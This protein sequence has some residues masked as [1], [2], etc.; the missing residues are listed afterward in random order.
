MLSIALAACAG[1]ETAATDAPSESPMSI[2]PSPS[3]TATPQPSATPTQSAAPSPSTSSGGGLAHDSMV[4]TVVDQVALRDGARTAGGLIGY[5]PIGSRS[6]V[7]DGPVSADGYEWM[8]LVGP[9]IPP[10]SGCATFPTRELT[11]PV[12]FGWA[13]IADPVSGDPWFADD[14]SECPEVD[15]GDTRAIMMLG[16][17]E[18]LHCF[19]GEQIEP[20][21]WL[22]AESVNED[23]SGL[24]S[25]AWLVC[26]PGA[27]TLF[28]AQDEAVSI[29]LYVDPS[30][31]VDLSATTGHVTVIGHVDHPAAQ[32]CSTAFVGHPDNPA[33]REVNCRTRFVVDRVAVQAP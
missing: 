17:V 24:E 19:S 20:S 18:A 21:G 31:D 12:W 22:P 2:S 28:V 5:L 3:T 1:T 23:C 13:A 29:E 27:G 8:L 6:F 16:D 7:V 14:P 9:G 10:A 25:V 33:L 32:S 26:E 4:V 15:A 30:S 11:C